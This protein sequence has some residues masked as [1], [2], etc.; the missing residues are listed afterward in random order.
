MEGPVGTG[1]HDSLFLPLVEKP[2]NDFEENHLLMKYMGEYHQTFIEVKQK[3][4]L[5]PLRYGMTLDNE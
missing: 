4:H 2:V 3:K 1:G 5:T